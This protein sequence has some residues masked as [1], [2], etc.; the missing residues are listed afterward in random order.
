MSILC[1]AAGSSCADEKISNEKFTNEVVS[2]SNTYY[3]YQLEGLVN[4]RVVN[5]PGPT[6][7]KE[8]TGYFARQPSALEKGFEFLNAQKFDGALVEFQKAILHDQNDSEAYVGLA[9]TQMKMNQ[10]DLANV[11]F[12]KAKELYE[13]SEDQTGVEMIEKY[14]KALE[15]GEKVYIQ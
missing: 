12:L 4:P 9:Y 10:N 6:S 8:D 15:T 11:N 7:N 3:L 13:K 1:L 14:L 5:D 2:E